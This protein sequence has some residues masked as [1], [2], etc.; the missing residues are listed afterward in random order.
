MEVEGQW[1]WKRDGSGS[2]IE[3]EVRWKWKHDC[4]CTK[5]HAKNNPSLGNKWSLQSRNYHPQYCFEPHQAP[6]EHSHQVPACA[7][8]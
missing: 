2:R 5:W 6:V 7:E 4:N 3:V 1:K 8:V